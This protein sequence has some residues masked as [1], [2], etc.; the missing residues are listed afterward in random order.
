M[1]NDGMKRALIWTGV[2]VFILFHAAVDLWWIDRHTTFDG[3]S[4]GD[5]VNKA[6]EFR[7]FWE[8]KDHTD[9]EK[10]RYLLCREERT[11]TPRLLFLYGWWSM[12]IFGESLDSLLY[13]M[14][15]WHALLLFATYVF[16]RVTVGE[17][18]ALLGMAI[19]AFM[20]QV[21]DYARSYSM[22]CASAAIYMFAL[23]A[24][25]KSEGLT[26]LKPGIIF[27]LLAATQMLTERGTPFL[28][29]AGPLAVCVWPTVKEIAQGRTRIFFWLNILIG[30]MIFYVLVWPYLL[31]YLSL[32]VGHIG[33]RVSQPYFVPGDQWYGSSFKFAYYLVELGLRQA[34]PLTA[35][36]FYLSL[37]ALWR[38]PF[39]N[40]RFV[41]ASLLAPFIIFTLIATKDV[42]YVLAWLPP[43]AL[44]AAHGI[45]SLPLKPLRMIA[46]AFVLIV[47]IFNFA[48]WSFGL[49]WVEK[50]NIADGSERSLFSFLT[51]WHGHSQPR[52]PD[53][54]WR[55]QETAEKIVKSAQGSEPVYVHYQYRTGG[56]DPQFDLAF[57][58]CFIDPR[59]ENIIRFYPLPEDSPD[60]NLTLVTIIPVGAWK[61]A[62]HSETPTLYRLLLKFDTGRFI[63]HHEDEKLAFDAYL[64]SLKRTELFSGELAP[65]YPYRVD[66]AWPPD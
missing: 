65:G 46:A 24:L 11:D 27:A 8:S 43:V 42:T 12:K 29:L 55:L 30:M 64:K 61:K 23:V 48:S 7:D 17:K 47:G 22:Y 35:L 34:G 58:V 36:V 37:I 50:Y 5:L 14:V 20:P 44:A 40:R 18:A 49:G 9:K 41:V 33:E 25:I 38:K 51:N 59:I 28:F 2:A 15:V 3:V 13:P 21:Y 45:L 4:E 52:K 26:R 63:E 31:G 62:G 66:V 57:Y 16:G 6:L 54:S 60:F 56:I 1:N 39:E 32:S 19:L 10:W 53:S